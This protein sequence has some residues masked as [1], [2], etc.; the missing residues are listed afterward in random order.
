LLA[1][2]FMPIWAKEVFYE[3]KSRAVGRDERG[4]SGRNG[5]H[6][7]LQATGQNASKRDQAADAE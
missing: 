5:P 7:L 2:I 4:Y 6:P 3:I 1:A